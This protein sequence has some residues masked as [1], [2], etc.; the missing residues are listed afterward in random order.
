SQLSANNRSTMCEP[1]SPV[2]PVTSARATGNRSLL[3][4]EGE[5]RHVDAPLTRFPFGVHAHAGRDLTPDHAERNAAKA[6]RRGGASDVADMIA[7][8]VDQLC[9][10]WRRVGA[11]RASPAKMTIHMAAKVNARHD[12]LPA[13]TPFR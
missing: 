12:R 5:Q 11:S 8:V 4:R 9:A 1:T 13:V 3:A 6:R 2:A 10:R 7:R